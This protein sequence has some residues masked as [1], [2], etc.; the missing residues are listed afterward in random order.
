MVTAAS[1]SDTDALALPPLREALNPDAL[2][3]LI[4]SMSEG[5]VSFTYGGERI[6]VNSSGEVELRNSRHPEE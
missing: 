3:N 6:T 5:H 2:D 1:E 4:R